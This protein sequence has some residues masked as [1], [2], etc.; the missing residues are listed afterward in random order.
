MQDRWGPRLK[1]GTQAVLLHFVGQSRPRGQPRFKGWGSGFH[2]FS[3]ESYKV[4]YKGGG[5]R[6]G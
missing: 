6:E 1:D 2:F 4:I 3:E 5:V